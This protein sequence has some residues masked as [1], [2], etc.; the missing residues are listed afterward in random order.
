M[1]G[2][3]VAK[4]CEFSAVRSRLLS[5]GALD[6]HSYCCIFTHRLM[7]MAVIEFGSL[8]ELADVADNYHAN[9]NKLYG[10]FSEFTLAIDKVVRNI[11]VSMY[12]HYID[13]WPIKGTCVG[14]RALLMRS[15]LEFAFING[16][17][18]HREWQLKRFNPMADNPHLSVDTLMKDN[19][20]EIRRMDMVCMF[21]TGME[22]SMLKPHGWLRCTI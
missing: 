21:K 19:E 10:N 2:K 7:V 20:E 12:T 14:H 8:K 13:R 22:P 6:C 5:G 11:V 4:R 16:C 9:I 17:Y 3:V 15:M 18:C 1:Q